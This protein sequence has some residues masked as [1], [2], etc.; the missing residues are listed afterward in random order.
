MIHSPGALGFIVSTSMTFGTDVGQH[1]LNSVFEG[2]KAGG[3]WG[4]QN[5]RNQYGRR[6]L[7]DFVITFATERQRITNEE[8]CYTS[9]SSGFKI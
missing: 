9:L 8:L 4:R 1:I 3:L 6:S 5:G 2:A 7:L